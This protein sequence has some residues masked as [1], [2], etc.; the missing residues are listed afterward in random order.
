MTQHRFATSPGVGPIT[1]PT[2]TE[3][4]TPIQNDLPNLAERTLLHFAVSAPPLEDVIM[5]V[6]AAQNPAYTP[7][8]YPAAET[9][10]SSGG[11]S[12]QMFDDPAA[13][14]GRTAPARWTHLRLKRSVLDRTLQLIAAGLSR[15]NTLN[16]EYAGEFHADAA[17][18]LLALGHDFRKYGLGAEHYQALATMVEETLLGPGGVLKNS[19]YAQMYRE[20]IE[21]TCH[22]LAIGAAESAEDKPQA[23]TAATVVEVIPAFTDEPDGYRPPISIIRLRTEPPRPWWSGQYL[24]VRTP[25][26]PKKWRCLSPAIPFNPDGLVEFHV[27]GVGDFSLGIINETQVGDQWAIG[28]NYGN[29]QV[30]VEL[31]DATGKPVVMVGGST[32]LAPLRAMILDLS[33]MAD[34]PQVTLYFGARRIAELYEI[35][36]MCSFADAWDW[37]TLIPVVQEVPSDDDLVNSDLPASWWNSLRI[38]PLDRVV[39][40]DG[41]AD[42]PQIFIAGSRTMTEA[43]VTRLKAHGVRESRIHYDRR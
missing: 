16:S 34:P 28:N 22:I 41:Q 25:Y 10:S 7:G 11:G 39:S 23:L 3:L 15:N 35:R 29:M 37:L 4:L 5:P 43:T 13:L 9:P 17:E 27:R 12:A 30:D 20:A 24:D 38:G 18:F 40:T 33:I 31:A 8:D 6:Y 42:K 14:A 2:V 26:T 19:E 32:G 21:M 36:S 1:N